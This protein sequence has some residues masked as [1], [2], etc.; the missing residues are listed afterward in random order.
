V[1]EVGQPTLT[2]DPSQQAF[3]H[4]L[5]VEPGAEHPHEALLLLGLSRSGAARFSFLLSI[6]IIVL[7]S[8]LSTLDLVEGEVAVDW[9]AMG[10]GVVL[11]AISA[12]LC[13]HFF[14][15]LLERVGMLPFVIYR[16]ILGAVLLV[17]FSGV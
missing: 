13:I 6:P 9:T 1:Q 3:G 17:L 8:G 4:R 2:V 10:L 16:L 12:Y 7:A 5:L 15:K 11:S 14:L